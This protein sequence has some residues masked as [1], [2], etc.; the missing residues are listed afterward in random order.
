MLP[1]ENRG[2]TQPATDLMAAATPPSP[3]SPAP[4]LGRGEKTYDTVRL[5]HQ[6]AH[7]PKDLGEHSKN[8]MAAPWSSAAMTQTSPTR[9]PTYSH[10]TSRRDSNQSS[11][12]F[13]LTDETSIA[14]STQGRVDLPEALSVRPKASWPTRQSIS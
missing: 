4:W 1:D 13:G 10:H 6:R 12:T 7:A 3:H 5:Q 11:T 2:L 8:G 14:G 9:P